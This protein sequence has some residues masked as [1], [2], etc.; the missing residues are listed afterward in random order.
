MSEH[1]PPLR[2]GISCGDL[3]GIGL[4]VVLK[5]FEDPRMLQDITPVVYASAKV[6]SFHRKA[7]RLEEI[8]FHRVNDAREAV[9]KKLNLVSLWEE[10]VPIEL[11]RPSG[12]LSAY[13]IKSLEAA[14]RIRVPRPHRIPGPCRRP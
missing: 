13:T 7:L 4:E 1:R 10:E 3:N 2:V 11:G 8:Q 9:P 5:T 14:V 6:L 12:K